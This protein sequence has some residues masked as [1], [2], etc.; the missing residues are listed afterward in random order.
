MELA[1][2]RFFHGSVRVRFGLA[3]AGYLIPGSGPQ[4]SWKQFQLL[5]P[6]QFWF[7][8]QRKGWPNLEIKAYML[9]P[10]NYHVGCPYL[11]HTLMDS[12]L[13]RCGDAESGL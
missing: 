7:W 8:D 3:A 11:I 10:F 12:W 2:V 1:T 5:G 6:E 13:V 4:P 9:G